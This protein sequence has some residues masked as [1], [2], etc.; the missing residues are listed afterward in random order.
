[1]P[2][3]PE[4]VQELYQAL[5][6]S[7]SKSPEHRALLRSIEAVNAYTEGLRKRDRYKRIPYVTAAQQQVLMDLH[8]TVADAAEKVLQDAFT[9]ERAKDTLRK[10]RKFFSR[11]G[12]ENLPCDYKLGGA[13]AE[14]MVKPLKSSADLSPVIHRVVRD[15]Y[16]RVLGPARLNKMVDISR[17]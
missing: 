4:T 10:L 14:L 8:K 15:F 12:Y 11:F 13:P 7:L 9:P 3:K 6:K 2:K 16:S 17:A 5:K 1:M